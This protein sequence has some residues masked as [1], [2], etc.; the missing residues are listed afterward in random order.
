[1]PDLPQ[2]GKR[3]VVIGTSGSGKTTTA[4]R[5]AAILGYPHVELDSLHWEAGWQE[6]PPDMFRERVAAAAS[7][8]CWVIDGNYSAV[9]D[10]LWS[11]AD[12]IVWLDYSLIVVLWRIWWRTL[13]RILQ[14]EEL[15]N[16]NRE[17]FRTQFLS[18]ES[19]F[20]WV[21]K[22]YWRRRREYPDLF[23]RPENG[24]LR[25]IRLSSARKAEMWLGTL[26]GTADEKRRSR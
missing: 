15:W 5:L 20:L 14:Q 12:T 13:H 1:M 21:L 23:S 25:V 2:P 4:G 16:G 7:G 18:R 26:R 19:L 22:T 8:P 11:R 10:A 24:H 3:I 9:R 17:S 6:A